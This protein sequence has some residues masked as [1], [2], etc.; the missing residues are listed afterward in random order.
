[1]YYGLVIGPQHSCTRLFVSILDKHPDTGH[2]GHI[3][4]NMPHFAHIINQYEKII[5]VSRDSSCVNYS[6]FHVNKISIYDDIASDAINII[7]NEINKIYKTYPGRIKDIIYVSY[8]SL[9]QYKTNYIKYILSQLNLNID[10]YDFNL[11][12]IYKPSDLITERNPLGKRWFSVNLNIIDSNKKYIIEKIKVIEGLQDIY[13]DKIYIIHINGENNRKNIIL[14][15]LN[16]FNLIY[17]VKWINAIENKK[18]PYIGCRESHILIIEDAYNN[19]YNNI[20]VLE[21]DAELLEFPFILNTKIPENW[22]MIYP[23]WFDID[24]KSFKISNDLIKLKS[25]RSTHCYIMNKKCFPY[26][27]RM[28]RTN[29]FIDMF[30]CNVIQNSLNCYGLYPL[31]ALQLEN[32]SYMTNHSNK[33]INAQLIKHAQIVYNQ[34]IIKETNQWR[35]HYNNFVSQYKSHMTINELRHIRL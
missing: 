4:S 6:N 26:F 16:K 33:K 35:Q 19:K 12:G 7:N 5:I 8:E 14:N 25:G 34:N 27:L 1:M 21:D 18:E 15:I 28:A 10:K 30:L 3:G 20:M 24:H 22:G 32:I 29:K 9:Y 31:R 13:V 23:G 2:I 17:K 11:T